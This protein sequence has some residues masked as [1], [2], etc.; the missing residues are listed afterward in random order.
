MRLLHQNQ[1]LNHHHHQQQQ[2]DELLQQQQQQQLQQQQQQELQ[3]QRILSL[4]ESSPPPPEPPE[5]HRLDLQPAPSFDPNVPP[6]PDEGPQARGPSIDFSDRGGTAVVGVQVRADEQVRK[7]RGRPPR[8][9]GAGG[10][11][12]SSTAVKKEE[13]EEDVC[14]ICFDGGTLVLCDRR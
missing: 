8:L 12:V 13:E 10:A 6:R 2:Q 4:F 11:V 3:R 5:D 1:P 14:F 9:N 7:R